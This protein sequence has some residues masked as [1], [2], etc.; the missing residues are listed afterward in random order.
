M[1]AFI[2]QGV[3]AI[4]T[5]ASP[6][7][8]GFSY[9]LKSD[10][11]NLAAIINASKTDNRAKY[12]ASPIIMTVDN[13]EAT[14]DATENRQFVTGWTAQSGAYGNSGQPTPNYSSK[15]IGIKIR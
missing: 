6:I 12:I 14:I 4:T 13:K 1:Q 15:D 10:K 3:S 7:G 9:L 8:G 5:N 2:E 11:L